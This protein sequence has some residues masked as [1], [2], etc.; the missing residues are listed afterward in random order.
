MKRI[1]IIALMFAL[2]LLTLMMSKAEQTC[3]AGAIR[4]GIE[5]QLDMLD[6]EPVKALVGI[7][8]LALAG[9]VNCSEDAY[10]FSGT[11]GAQPVLGPMA[12]SPGFYILAMTT[13]GAARVQGVALEGCGKDVNGTL[14]SFSAGEA[15]R[16]AENLFQVE[17]EC[18]L[19]LELSKISAPW[20]LSIDK[21][22]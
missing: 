19:Y 1:G 5:A 22:R 18:I 21:I 17:E 4:K 3:N 11:R 9:F 10:S 14:H 15:F 6:E 13:D 2:L 20:T 8:N 7:M 16:G 12:L